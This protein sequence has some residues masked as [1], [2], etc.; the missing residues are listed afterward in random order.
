M[1]KILFLL[2]F[3][4]FFISCESKNNAFKYFEKESIEASAIRHTKKVDII[5]D[6]QVDTVF[7]ASYLNKF[8]L[9]ENTK[10]SF[11]VYI[12]SN[13]QSKIKYKILLNNKEAIKMEKIQKDD[14]RYKKFML[15]NFW[16]E[17]YLV[18][19]EKEEEKNL[20]LTLKTKT[21]AATVS[22]QK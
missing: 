18:E 17:Y 22:F 13:N 3:S 15:K 8:L 14:E 7:M 19:F 9:K 5:K 11:L 2:V 6:K 21:N 1:K 20:N 16:G 10:D 12:Y 4:L